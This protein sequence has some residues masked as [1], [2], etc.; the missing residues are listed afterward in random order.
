MAYLSGA[1]Q[2]NQMPGN[3]RK[4]GNLKPTGVFKQ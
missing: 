2:T 4:E 3:K 1:P